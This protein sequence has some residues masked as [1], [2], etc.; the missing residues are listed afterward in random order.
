MTS[1]SI[2]PLGLPSG[3]IRAILA[4]IIV[5]VACQ[6]M[7]S[8]TT[9]SLLLSETLMIVLTY[10]F[11]IRQHFSINNKLETI[12]VETNPLWLPRGSIRTLIIVAFIIT[13]L[14]LIAQGRL[15]NSNVLGMLI[16]FAAYLLGNFFRN[17]KISY[18]TFPHWFNQMLV[19]ITGLLVILIG[20]I[21]LVLA[22]NNLLPIVPEWI[23]SLLLSAI[24]YY[25]GVR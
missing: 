11:T 19:H 2:R 25:F 9:P 5:T 3:S 12:T 7:L 24:V 13:V 8:G 17:K 4:L 1:S 22:F 15:F 23:A 14:S 16:P 21:L 20:L 6:Q 10:Y 18:F